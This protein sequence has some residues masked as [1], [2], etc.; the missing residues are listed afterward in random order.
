MDSLTQFL[1]GATIG[2][3]VAGKRMGRSAAWI[4]GVL[5]TVPDLDVFI[6]MPDDVSAFTYHRGASHSL[7]LLG[8]A[9]PLIAWALSRWLPARK[10]DFRVWLWVCLLALL[11]HPLLDAMTVYGTQLLWPLTEYPFAVGSMFIIDP[12]YSLPL[13]LTFLMAQSLR[14]DGE[15]GQRFSR[16]ALWF[17]TAYLGLSVV[18]Q[19]YVTGIVDDALARERIKP[20]SKIVMSTPFNTLAWRAVAV[21]DDS[22]FVGYYSL[23]AP[24]EMQFAHYSNAQGLLEPIADTWAVQRLT[25]FTKGNYAVRDFG[26][27]IVLSDLRMGLEPDHYVFSFVVGKR[28]G[29]LIAE[30]DRSRVPGAPYTDADWS[31]LRET[32][33]GGSSAT[34]P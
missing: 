23:F 30:G 25:W 1:L 11:T 6:Q 3:A 19:T 2:E 12:V 26:D 18:L 14:G 22:Y 9:A 27:R 20:R 17:S 15:R 4:G 13:L 7:I 16:H 29:G 8:I 21:T 5:A 31:A 33:F 24:S 32:I 10:R 28:Q 34:R